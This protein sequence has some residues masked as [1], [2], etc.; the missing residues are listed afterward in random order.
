MNRNLGQGN[1]LDE[2]ELKKR[3]VAA[4]RTGGYHVAENK[5]LLGNSVRA[6]NHY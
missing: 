2:P 4:L 1:D 5:V 3:V 6:N